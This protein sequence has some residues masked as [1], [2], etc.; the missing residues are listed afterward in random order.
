MDHPLLSNPLDSWL[1]F[2]LAFIVGLVVCIRT[3]M[4]GPE[5][6]S[7]SNTVGKTIVITGGNSGIGKETAIE[8]ARRGGTIILACKNL[9]DGNNAVQEIVKLSGNANV[10]AMKLDLASFKSVKQFAKEFCDK[11]SSLDVLINN[12]G[13]MLCPFSKTEDG[14]EYH[15]QVNHLSHFLLTNLLLDKLKAVPFGKIINVSAVA[16]K[17]ASLHFDDPN[18]DNNYSSREAYGHSKLAQ[19]LCARHLSKKLEGT[20]VT[21]NSV[22]PGLV[23]NTK[24][25]RHT[26]VYNSFL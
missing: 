18:L 21:V 2:Q 16:H 25:L 12:A 10:Q 6:P 24:I 14:N 15:F 26:G 8:L 4:R 19:L 23:K 22:H 5:C 7:T 13:V 1:P 9:E 3:Y 17:A 20:R 11:F